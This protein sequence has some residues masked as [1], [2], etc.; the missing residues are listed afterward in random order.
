M[1][2]NFKHYFIKKSVLVFDTVIIF[3]YFKWNINTTHHFTQT[4]NLF[5]VSLRK[6]EIASVYIMK[7]DQ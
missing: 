3:E 7:N 4:I 5:T 2:S 6:K 1:T